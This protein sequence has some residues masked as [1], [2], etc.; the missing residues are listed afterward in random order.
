MRVDYLMSLLDIM[1]KIQTNFNKPSNF[2]SS[3]IIRKKE[4]LKFMTRHL[5]N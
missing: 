3:A 1:L 4:I 2:S 5:Q